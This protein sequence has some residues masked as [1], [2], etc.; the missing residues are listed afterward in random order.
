MGDT[1]VLTLDGS[2]A[3]QRAPPGWEP[4]PLDQ[5][6]GWRM[7]DT[8]AR[9]HGHAPRDEY[10]AFREAYGVNGSKARQIGPP[11]WA[12]PP[13][14]QMAGWRQGDTEAFTLDGGKAKYDWHD[15]GPLDQQAGWRTVGDTEAYTFDGSKAR[16]DWHDRGPLDQQAA[17]RMG[18][19]EAFTLDGSKAR[20]HDYG[21]LDQ[22]GGW[23]MGD[24]EAFT[25]DGSKARE[26]DYGPLD[27]KGAWRLGDK[28]PFTLDW[29]P[30]VDRRPQMRTQQYSS[31]YT[32]AQ[33]DAP[34]LRGQGRRQYCYMDMTDMRERKWKPANHPPPGGYGRSDI[35]LDRNERI[36]HK[37]LELE[38]GARAEAKQ[39]YSVKGANLR[40]RHRFRSGNAQQEEA[41]GLMYPAHEPLRVVG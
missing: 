2:N 5:Q 11:G 24:T 12:P 36:V 22:K 17:W 13:L 31:W 38:H 20:E 26:H 15:R 18:D 21:P 9:Q 16:Y 4:A 14:D 35:N 25:F 3:R 29:R 7:G 32:G 19:T 1:E 41:G 39:F 37:N 27:Q 33:H 23:R 28:A 10:A 30:S 40:F 6:A 34:A 8:E